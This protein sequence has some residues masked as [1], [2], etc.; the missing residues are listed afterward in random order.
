ML[1]LLRDGRHTALPEALREIE[2]LLHTQLAAALSPTA[3]PDYPQLMDAFWAVTDQLREFILSVPLRRKNV[4]ALGGSF[5]CGKSSIVNTLVGR[6]VLPT[7]IVPTTAVATYVVRGEPAASA[8]NRDFFT[9]HMQPEAVGLITHGFYGPDN[10][11]TDYPQEFSHHLRSLLVW[12][13]G[14]PYEQLALLDTPGYTGEQN[15]DTVRTML[16]GASALVWVINAESGT[17]TGEEIRFLQTLNTGLE[18]LFVINKCDKKTAYD[19]ALIKRQVKSVLEQNGIAY[20]DIATFSCR[21]PGEYEDALLTDFLSKW[22]LAAPIPQFSQT[23]YELFSR[24]IDFYTDRQFTIGRRLNK[25]NT[26]LSALPAPDGNLID[27]VQELR[28]EGRQ[29]ARQKEQMQRIR[30]MCL[31]ALVRLGRQIG[32]PFPPPEQLAEVQRKNDLI[33]LVRFVREKHAIR[34]GDTYYRVALAFAGLDMQMQFARGGVA[35]EQ[36]L[37]ELLLRAFGTLRQ[38]PPPF[39]ASL[40][41]SQRTRALVAHNLIK[42]S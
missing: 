14:F 41:V 7:E 16:A 34:T 5:S 13:P 27:V 17:L 35:Y 22:N 25:V 10:E 11:Q 9:H 2:E 37:A 20:E 15:S 40:S 4:V 24:C 6:R 3:P 21:R 19:V 38:T 31:D 29:L 1:G 23:Y 39:A 32:T 28:E 33:S 42:E 8:V 30:S 18:K 36:T 26:A 12:T